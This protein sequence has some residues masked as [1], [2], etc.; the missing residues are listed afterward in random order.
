MFRSVVYDWILAR[1]A[2]PCKR[3]FAFGAK[4]IIDGIGATCLYARMKLTDYLN[5]KTVKVAEFAA[6]VGRDQSVVARW[7]R[8]EVTPDWRIWP[9]ITAATRGAV[10]PV[11]FM[12]SSKDSAA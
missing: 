11:D 4:I 2:E 5:Q 6:K 10:K 12:P 7:K 1:H 8:G 3:K 9:K